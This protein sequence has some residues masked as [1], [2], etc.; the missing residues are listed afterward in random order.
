MLDHLIEEYSIHLLHQE[1]EEGQDKGI[2]TN[3]SREEVINL[4]EAINLKGTTQGDHSRVMA[5]VVPEEG[6]DHYIVVV[7]AVAGTRSEGGHTN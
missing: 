3:G 5:I 2:I 7:V 1:E 6:E 4:E